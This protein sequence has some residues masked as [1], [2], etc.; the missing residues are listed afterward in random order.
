[1]TTADSDVE[2]EGVRVV[3]VRVYPSGNMGTASWSDPRSMIPVGC[4][5]AA[6]ERPVMH[7][8]SVVKVT[9]KK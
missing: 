8:A 9:D 4:C 7:A 6:G 2:L 5:S 1:M 3:G